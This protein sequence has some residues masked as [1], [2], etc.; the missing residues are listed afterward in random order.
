M[1]VEFKNFDRSNLDHTL[2]FWPFMVLVILVTNL[3]WLI[4]ATPL[5]DFGYMDTGGRTLFFVFDFLLCNTAHKL[6][7]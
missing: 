2:T 7:C 4:L 6:P 5:G 3:I 1:E